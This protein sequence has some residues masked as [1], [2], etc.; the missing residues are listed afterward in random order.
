MTIADQAY[1]AG[2]DAITIASVD[3]EHSDFVLV[4]AIRRQV[5]VEEQGVAEAEEWDGLDVSSRHLLARRG[6]EPLG[7]LRYYGDEGWLH[8]GRV[9]VLPVARGLGLGRL[10]LADC[11]RRGAEKGFTRSFLNAQTDK[12]GFYEKLGYHTVGDM[13][14]EAGI[15]HIRMERYW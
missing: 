7:T 8:V 1:S 6:N 15:P 10:L 14:M 11:L 4:A 2:P 5:F 9:A 12:T 13:F 3:R